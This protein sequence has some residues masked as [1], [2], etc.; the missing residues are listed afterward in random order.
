M[1]ALPLPQVGWSA[2]PCS[3]LLTIGHWVLLSLQPHK[4]LSPQCM[5]NYCLLNSAR[6]CGG[7]G[8]G[9]QLLF[10]FNMQVNHLESLLKCRF[11]LS[12]SGVYLSVCISK[13]LPRETDT[14]GPQ[15]RLGM[16]RAGMV[17]TKGWGPVTE[18]SF[19]YSWKSLWFCDLGQINSLLPISVSWSIKWQQLDVPYRATVGI[20]SDQLKWK[21]QHGSDAKQE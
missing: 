11:W 4:R 1:T 3:Q 7:G 16:A 20:K 17:V 14:G 19:A 8:G 2:A 13:N 5:L 12:R 15:T 21:G 9:E 6:G 18:L 10:D